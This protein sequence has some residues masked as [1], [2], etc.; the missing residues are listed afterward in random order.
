MTEAVWVCVV[1]ETVDVRETYDRSGWRVDQSDWQQLHGPKA[2]G[3]D[4]FTHISRSGCFLC[5]CPQIRR[6][7][8]TLSELIFGAMFPGTL[9]P[10]RSTQVKHVQEWPSLF[11]N[12][13]LLG[14]RVCR[15]MQYDFCGRQGRLQM[16]ADTMVETTGA[17]STALLS[18]LGAADCCHDLIKTGKRLQHA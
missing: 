16:V 12:G 3:L 4:Q 1:V 5:V 11:M 2:A 13:S 15:H 6:A 9:R 17:L 7:D 14:T 10:M 18:A 8:V